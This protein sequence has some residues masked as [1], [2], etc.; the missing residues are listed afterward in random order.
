VI[1]H[2]NE[3]KTDN[4]IFYLCLMSESDH[5]KHH[6]DVNNIPHMKIHFSNITSMQKSKSDVYDIVMEDPYR[7][8]VAN[9]VVVHNCGK[10][11]AA[12]VSLQHLVS[13]LLREGAKAPKILVLLPKSM[14]FQ[15]RSETHKFTPNIYSNII[16]LPY[17]QLKKAKNL[18]IYYDFR[19]IVMDECFSKDTEILTERGFVKFPDLRDEEVAQVDQETLDISFVKPLRKIKNYSPGIMCIGGDKELMEVTPNHDLLLGRH[20]RKGG[21]NVDFVWEKMKASEAADRKSICRLVPRSGKAIGKDVELTPTEK[22]LIALQADGSIHR[23]SVAHSSYLFSF[24]K[25]RKIKDFEN[26]MSEGGFKFTKLKNYKPETRYLTYTKE[27]YTKKIYDYFDLTKLSFSKAVAIVDYFMKW[28]GSILP[29]SRYYSS[30]DEKAVDFLQAVCT[31]AGFKAVKIKQVDDRKES[32]KDVHRL[33]ISWSETSSAQS[34][35]IK[36]KE[37]ND[38]TYCVEVPKGNIVT[39]LRGRVVITGNSHYMKSQGTNRMEDFC[40][41]LESIGNSPGQFKGGKYISLSGTPM[42]NHA[43]E[44]YTTWALLT[45]QSP[46]EAVERMRDTDRYEKWKQAFTRSKLK[47]WKT[48]RGTKYGLDS[49]EGVQNEEM[50]NQLIGPVV[51]F[52]RACDCLD[53]PEKQEVEIN[54]GLEDDKLLLD[55]DIEKPE[56]YMAILER[57]AR[58]KTPHAV[59]WIETFLKG[60]SEQLIVFSPYKF[61]LNEIGAKFKKKALFITGDNNDRERKENVQ[62]FQAGTARILLTTYGAGG[63]GL[64]L[65]NCH[66]TLYLGFPWTPGAIEQAMARTHRSGQNKRTIHYFLSSGSCDSRIYSLIR[67]KKEAISAV[68]DGLLANEKKIISGVDKFI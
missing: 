6:S 26:L 54:L 60:S 48:K 43:G 44:L 11:L 32:Y 58:A 30:T 35:N 51:H 17:S 18:S 64:N 33:F 37:Y 2:I 40:S 19:A 41:L 38:Y 24:T 55:A 29:S 59:Q 14:L 10:T 63:V 67:I 31:L 42:L 47:S 39:R 9:G 56:A 62:A 34:W 65:Q 13:K 16:F 3:I 53:L 68:E 50:F 45:S 7:N 66:N 4:N 36:R 5:A 27:R 1:Q 20:I 21:V 52:R 8:F 15:W 57:L 61:P 23:H 25:Q 46:F 28:D 49:P 12:L 22:F